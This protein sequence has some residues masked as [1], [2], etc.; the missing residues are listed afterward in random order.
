MRGAAEGQQLQLVVD[1]D[2]HTLA[3]GV[4]DDAPVDMGVALPAAVTPY[5]FFD[6]RDDAVELL[7]S[8]VELTER[9]PSRRYEERAGKGGGNKARGVLTDRA[10]AMKGSHQ[11][12]RGDAG[13][14]GGGLGTVA[15]D[16]ADEE[17]APKPPP[18][19]REKPP[20]APPP[21]G[22]FT[23]PMHLALALGALTAVHK[24]DPEA[25]AMA[26]PGFSLGEPTRELLIK[27]LERLHDRIVPGLGSGAALEA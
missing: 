3:M 2:A 5:V 10:K 8:T 4:N 6:W 11:I 21:E 12:E 19:P 16:G 13:R 24:L 25:I 15:E 20:G 26:V 1:M 9:Q 27:E 17:A 22:G 14:K 7:G 23:E 18:K